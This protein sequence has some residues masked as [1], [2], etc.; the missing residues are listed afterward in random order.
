MDSAF[1]ME[2]NPTNDL[3]KEQDYSVWKKQI[4]NKKYVSSFLSIDGYTMLICPT[5][6]RNKKFTYLC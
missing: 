6:K 3:N 2:Y 5:P 4:G 1:K